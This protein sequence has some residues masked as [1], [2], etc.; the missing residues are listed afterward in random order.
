MP[1]E[2]HAILLAAGRSTRMGQ[3]KTLLPW[4]STTVIETCI[5]NLFLAG[6]DNVIVVLNSSSDLTSQAVARSRAQIAFNDEPECEMGLSISKG[7]ERVPESSGAVLIALADQ[8]AVPPTVIS[9]L[10]TNWRE[11]KSEIVIPVSNGRGGHPIL[12]DGSLLP[13]LRRLDEQIGLRGLLRDSASRT[14][15]IEVGSQF[16][17]RDIDTWSEYVDLHKEVFGEAPGIQEPV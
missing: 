3:P 9:F 10:V 11:Q 8:P 14:L 12:I 13:R 17:L 6:V 2:V 16:I 7:A 5:R 4:G 15:R 1:G